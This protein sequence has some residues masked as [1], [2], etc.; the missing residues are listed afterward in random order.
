[1]GP[2]GQLMSM[3]PGM[4][5]M[6]K[7]GPGGGRPRRPQ[8]DRGDHP[9][10]D[11]AR[12]AR[13]GRP[14][15]LAPAADRRRLRAPS[16]PD[17]N[18]L[19]KQ[20][21]EMQK[22]MKQLSGGGS[23]GRARRPDRAGDEPE[24]SRMTRADPTT[25]RRRPISDRDAAGRAD[26]P[27]ADPGAATPS[28]A[29]SAGAVEPTPPTARRAGPAVRG[30]PG[31]EPPAAA[32]R[33]RWAIALGGVAIVVASTAAIV[34]LASGAPERLDRVGYMPERH[35]R[36]TAR[37]ASTCPATSAQKRRRRS[38]RSS[39]ASPTRPRSRR[40]ST[41]SSTGSSAR[42][43]NGDADLHAPTSSRGSAARSRSASAAAGPGASIADPSAMAGAP[44]PRRSSRSRTAAAALAWFDDDR[45][46]R[47]STD[48]RD[49]QRRDALTV[50]GDDGA[51]APYASRSTDK[52]VRRR[53]PSPSVKA[54]VDTE[55]RRHASPTTPTF[56]AA[57]G[58]VDERPR[59]VRVRRLPVACVQSATGRAAGG[60]RGLG[61]T[62]VDDELLATASRP[63]PPRRPASRTTRSSCERGVPVDRRRLRRD[64]PARATL[65]GHVPRDADRLVES[66][67]FGDGAHGAPRRV[68]RH[69]GASSE[70]VRPARPGARPARRRR[71]R[72][73][74]DRRRRGRRRRRRRRRRSRAASSSPRPTRGGRRDFFGCIRSSLV[75]RRRGAGHRRPRRVAHGDTTITID[76]PQRRR[77]R[78]GRRRGLPPGCQGVELAYAVTD[79]VVVDRLRARRSS[80]TSSTRRRRPRSPA[81]PRYKALARARRRGEPRRHV[82]RHHRDPRAARAAVARRELP[83]ETWATTSAR[84]SRS[85]CRSTR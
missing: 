50:P 73:R 64:E 4:G 51:R 56:K 53:R 25:R 49:V 5:G 67:D 34:A 71:R 15:R 83:A 24:E 57:L 77:C 74:L 76:R 72:H 21:A 84:S 32:R 38:C 60:R 48:D 23:R 2:I 81:T 52:V 75:A 43:S 19:V 10:D 59:R 17:V 58:I 16:L 40:S 33:R 80:S 29:P 54:A 68:P 82:R 39:R 26:A 61:S 45:R 27:P 11:A 7:R 18:R 28:T 22:L 79:D 3:I 78:H 42:R 65:A 12:A 46:E 44:R 70:H 30:R 47:R 85:S 55:G 9:V 14:Q 41:R 1:M 8:A 62:A 31:A 35:D 13:P 20:F 36:R 37:S 6:A 66:H 63:G 69:A